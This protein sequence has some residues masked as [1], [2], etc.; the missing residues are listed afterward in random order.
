M[1]YR[2]YLYERKKYVRRTYYT[3]TKIYMS[4]EGN[5][6]K[7]YFF[8]WNLISFKMNHYEIL[9]DKEGKRVKTT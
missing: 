1:F 3:L 7:Y 4:I 9:D 5:I 8:C 6:L 2:N